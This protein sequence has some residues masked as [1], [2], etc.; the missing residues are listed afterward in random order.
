MELAG[1]TLTLRYATPADAAALLSL[2]SDPRVTRFFSWGPYTE[3]AQ[4]LA[5]IARLAGER[6]RGDQLDLLV[7]HREHGPIGVTGLAEF[8]RRDR[9]AVVGTWFGRDW[10]GRGANDES[11]ALIA[12]LAF[13]HLG[14][15]RVGAYADVDN[16]RS[17]AALERIGFVREGV[18]RGWHRHGENVRDVVLFSL[19]RRDFA[20]SRLAAVPTRLSGEPPP[21]FVVAPVSR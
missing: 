13:D 20:G 2:A 4:P 17:Q 9:R 15:D 12:R 14:L 6:E 3:L 18:L 16:G 1:P 21:A 19:L 10:W 11:K 8:S 7:V 5:Y